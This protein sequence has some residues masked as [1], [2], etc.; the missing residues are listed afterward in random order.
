[1]I[2]STL[3]VSSTSGMEFNPP[4]VLKRADLPSMT[5]SDAAGPMSPRPRTAVPS[6]TTTTRR[7]AQVWVAAL[8]G[9]SAMARDT[10]AT[11]GVYA[12]DRARLESSGMV[13][14]TESL[15]P[16]WEAKISSPVMGETAFWGSVAVVGI[17]APEESL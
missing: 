7:E 6:E 5:G 2:S 9:S 16:S 3:V 11:P 4:K 14:S 12:T 15:P 8:A 17:F 10:W 13:H 1:M